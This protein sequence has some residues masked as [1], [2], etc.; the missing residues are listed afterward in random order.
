V[1]VKL[2][3]ETT[4]ALLLPVLTHF[5]NSHTLPS[6]RHDKNLDEF[7]TTHPW[8]RPFS[9]AIEMQHIANPKQISCKN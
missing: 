7:T 2:S 1:I 8:H 3:S 4:D 5:V 6:L 9:T